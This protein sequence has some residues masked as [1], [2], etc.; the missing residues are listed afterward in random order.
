MSW[1]TFKSCELTIFHY[2]RIGL[3]RR[4]RKLEIA[5][6]PVFTPEIASEIAPENAPKMNWGFLSSPRHGLVGFASLCRIY[7]TL[8][9]CVGLEAPMSP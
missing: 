5:G 7:T 6:T 2:K 9:G 8:R 3:Y 1:D 4:H